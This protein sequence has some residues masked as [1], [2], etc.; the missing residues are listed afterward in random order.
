MNQ[1]PEAPKID[2]RVQ[3]LVSALNAIPGVY[4]Y[5]SCGGHAAPAEGQ[6]ARDRFTVSLDLERT[7]RGWKALELIQFAIHKSSAADAENIIIRPWR[8]GDGTWKPGA[9]S[10]SLDGRRFADPDELAGI[11]EALL[12]ELAGGVPPGGATDGARKFRD[13][14]AKLPRDPDGRSGLGTCLPNVRRGLANDG[15]AIAAGPR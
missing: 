7:A 1:P 2:A 13:K 10:F 15:Y 5:S 14:A 8:N 11:I 4:T 3:R 6:V 12:R 9:L